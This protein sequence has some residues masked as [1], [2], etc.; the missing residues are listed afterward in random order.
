M[1]QAAVGRPLGEPDLRHERRLHPVR[2]L[3]RS[4]RVAER[5]RPGLDGF[6][7]LDELRELAVVEARTHPPRV[8]EIAVVVDAQDERAEIHPRL[9]RLGP[10]RDDE[11]LFGQDL[12]LAPVGCALAGMVERRRLLR[13]QAFP[14]AG[15]RALVH[16]P[17]VAEHDLA[18][19]DDGRRCAGQEPF[20]RL[21]ALGE[22]TA[23]EVSGAVAQDVEADVCAVARSS[24]QVLEAGRIA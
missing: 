11:L 2:L 20:E 15:D 4:R 16:L 10:A 9:A 1:A 5:S 17:A 3:V 18:D 21:P 13:D 19:A 6:Q 12:D 8:Q 23:A 7:Q 22:R 14:A 24:L